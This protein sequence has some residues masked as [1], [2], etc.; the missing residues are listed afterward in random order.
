[1]KLLGM[2]LLIVPPLLYKEIF[3]TITQI[4]GIKEELLVHAIGVL[5]ILFW[6]QFANFVT[7]RLYDYFVISFQMNIQEWL[8]NTFLQKL[9]GHSFQF[10]TNNFT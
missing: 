8:N 3:D 2:I 1:M 5:V 6:I 4:G 9:Q 7:Y 10:F